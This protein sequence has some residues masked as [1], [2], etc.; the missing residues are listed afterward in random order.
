MWVRTEPKTH[1][2][3]PT[4]SHQLNSCAAA[5]GTQQNTFHHGTKLG[6]QLGQEQA[7]A[8][9]A[10]FEC[11]SISGY[12]RIISASTRER[13]GW[14]DKRFAN[15]IQ[16]FGFTTKKAQSSCSSY[17][18]TLRKRSSPTELY[19]LNYLDDS[20]NTNSILWRKVVFIMIEL[21]SPQKKGTVIQV[22]Q[23]V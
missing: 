4:E 9:A 16:M 23:K 3:P 6:Q 15:K 17:K 18:P 10:M 19:Y 21:T 7:A 11:G 12:F 8:A 13:F 1:V 14:W 20:K 2:V 5:H 22:L